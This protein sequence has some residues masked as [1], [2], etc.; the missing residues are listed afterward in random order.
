MQNTKILTKK[1]EEHKS[2]LRLFFIPSYLAIR[3]H[4]VLNNKEE[5][6]AAKDGTLLLLPKSFERLCIIYSTRR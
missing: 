3:S 1:Q 5:I 6:A 2:F 4:A